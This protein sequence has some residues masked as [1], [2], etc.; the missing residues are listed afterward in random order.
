MKNFI[1]LFN[2]YIFKK[3]FKFF[4]SFNCNPFQSFIALLFMALCCTLLMFVPQFKNSF[5]M[6]TDCNEIYR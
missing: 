3:V 5:G 1:N 4:I 2:K 6:G